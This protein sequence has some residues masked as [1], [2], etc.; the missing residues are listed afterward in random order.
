M[1][2]VF[3]FVGFQKSRFE[4]G[5]FAPSFANTCVE[6]GR[7]AFKMLKPFDKWARLAVNGNQMI[8]ALI[9]GLFLCCSPSDIS[10]FVVSTV[11]DSVQ[12]VITTGFGADVIGEGIERV[13]PLWGNCDS[14]P[15]IIGESNVVRIGTTV[16]DTEPGIVQ[17][18][19]ECPFGCFRIT[20]DRFSQCFDIGQSSTDTVSECG[21]SQTEFFKPFGKTFGFSVDRNAMVC[22]RVPVLSG[23]C[24]PLAIFRGIR[25]IVVDSVERMRFVGTSPHIEQKRFISIPSVTYSNSAS[26]VSRE[27]GMSRIVASRTHTCPSSIFVAFASVRTLAVTELNVGT[28]FAPALDA[29]TSTRFRTSILEHSA[30]NDFLVAANAPTSPTSI[31]SFDDSETSKLLPCEIYQS[32]NQTMTHHHCLSKGRTGV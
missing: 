24:C 30:D 27:L 22:T 23:A 16:F 9:A 18:S 31:F 14:A 1:M 6:G 11:V 3:A 12:G 15:T 5:F 2:N 10:R 28:M 25:S 29:I 13:A 8:A 19:F 17:R 20:N 26:A 21:T 4:R 32:H 7:V